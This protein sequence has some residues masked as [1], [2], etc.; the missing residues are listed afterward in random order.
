MR[1]HLAGLG[2]IALA[3]CAQV[4]QVV[5]RGQLPDH[6]DFWLQQLVH[7]AVLRRALLTG[8]L[9]LWNPALAGGTPHLADPQSATLYP[10]TTFPL[11]LL[12]PEHVARLTIP[13]HI[14]LAGAGAYALALSFGTSRVAALTAGLGY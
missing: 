11:L 13:L 12:A 1:R 3:A 6:Y 14:A 9:P 10:L 2:V 5:L 7:L 4:H 8:E